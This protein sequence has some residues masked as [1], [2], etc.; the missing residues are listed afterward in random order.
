MA[1]IY[2]KFDQKINDQIT[3]NRLQQ[4][5]NRPATIASYDRSS[6]SATVIMDE[7]HS[8]TV[9][10]IV[11]KVPCPFTYGIQ[12]VAP[13]VGQRCLVAFRNDSERDPYIVSFFNEEY[14]TIKTIKNHKVDTG[15]PKFLS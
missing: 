14:D 8:G 4:T 11:T 15:I 7:R 13:H 6:N 3:S 1:I 9:G 5:R 10:D 12:T 2:P